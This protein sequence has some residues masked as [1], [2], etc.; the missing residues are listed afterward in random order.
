MYDKALVKIEKIAGLIYVAIA[1]LT[2]PGIVV[3][4]LLITTINYFVYDLGDE[5]FFLPFRVMYV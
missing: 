4:A 5:S 2:I 1:K 3:P